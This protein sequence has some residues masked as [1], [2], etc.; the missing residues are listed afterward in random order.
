MLIVLRKY[1]SRLWVGLRIRMMRKATE[2]LPVAM[3]I[4]AKGYNIQLT[5]VR[6]FFWESVK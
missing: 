6:K 1:R 3:A 5:F 4:I 2:T